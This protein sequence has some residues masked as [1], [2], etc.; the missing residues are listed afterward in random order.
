MICRVVKG[1]DG[2]VRTKYVRD[3]GT[4]EVFADRG[5]VVAVVNGFEMYWEPGTPDSVGIVD[6]RNP[7]GEN[8]GAIYL[9][10]SEIELLLD[11]RKWWAEMQG[12][13]PWP[14]EIRENSFEAV[15]KAVNEA[16]GSERRE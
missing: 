3:P 7:K 9:N 4:A 6:T 13:R 12:E 11:A 14:P 8:P 16:D 2:I 10:L 1:K 15:I 5:S